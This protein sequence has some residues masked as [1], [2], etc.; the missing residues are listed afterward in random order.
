M[1]YINKVTG[2]ELCAVQVN[3]DTPTGLLFVTVADF[4]KVGEDFTWKHGK[5]D[6]KQW[7]ISFKDYQN[8]TIELL[9]DQWLV[10]F[11]NGRFIVWDNEEFENG[12]KKAENPSKQTMKNYIRKCNPLFKELTKN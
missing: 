3:K 1:R 4:G 5:N 8:K 2:S 9:D 11:G 12:F 6:L 10:M 7:V